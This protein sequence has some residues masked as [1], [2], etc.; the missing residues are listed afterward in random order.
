MLSN[1][2]IFPVHSSRTQMEHQDRHTMMKWYCTFHARSWTHAY[3][4]ARPFTA[5][6]QEIDT[7][8]QIRSK[9]APERGL[10]FAPIVNSNSQID[11]TAHEFVRPLLPALQTN[12]PD[13]AQNHCPAPHPDGHHRPAPI[14]PRQVYEIVRTYDP[15]VCRSSSE[16]GH[17]ATAHANHRTQPWCAPGSNISPPQPRPISSG[18]MSLSD[19]RRYAS[20]SSSSGPS[21]RE[22]FSEYLHFSRMGSVIGS[23]AAQSSDPSRSSFVL[24]SA[25]GSLQ[26][27]AQLVRLPPIYTAAEHDA[28]GVLRSISSGENSSASSPSAP[29]GQDRR[30]IVSESSGE[31]YDRV[32]SEE[33][34]PRA[35][36][37]PKPKLTVQN[38]DTSANDEDTNVLSTNVNGNDDDAEMNTDS[39]KDDNNADETDKK[40]AEGK[41]KGANQTEKEDTSRKMVSHFFGRNKQCTKA[42]P[43]D[44]W[45]LRPR[46]NYQQ[47]AYRSRKDGLHFC[48]YSKVVRDQLRRIDEWWFEKT[49]TP[50][51]WNI[52]FRVELAKELSAYQREKPNKPHTPYVLL[53]DLLEPRIG[54]GKSSQDCMDLIDMAILYTRDMHDNMQADDLALETAKHR[55][56]FKSF[57]KNPE[58]VMFELLPQITGNSGRGRRPQTSAAGARGRASRKR[59][60]A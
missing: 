47:T 35:L 58:L 29:I 25:P 13:C 57:K 19:P 6:R 4:L 31:G 44:I 21:S 16:Q 15:T 5:T 2:S 30:C 37:Q 59:N 22:S 48:V 27:D 3:L 38:N 9:P 18:A 12:L 11:S 36:P 32:M 10:G 7:I 14:E 17:T 1:N 20:A 60:A 53:A 28:A 34:S 41:D 43:R 55:N 49:G 39:N 40:K 24:L 33:V 56:T 42:I 23:S 26:E 45:Y 8:M 46:K 54:N 50:V 51:V 52:I